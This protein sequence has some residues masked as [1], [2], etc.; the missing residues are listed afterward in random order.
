MQMLRQ[1]LLPGL[2]ERLMM[3]TDCLLPSRLPRRRQTHLRRLCLQDRLPRRLRVHLQVQR[4]RQVVIWMSR[5]LHRN[6]REMK[7]AMTRHPRDARRERHL[8]RRLTP[9]LLT[10]ARVPTRGLALDM[11]V[12][13]LRYLEASVVWPERLPESTS[14]RGPRGRQ[15]HRL[16]FRFLVHRTAT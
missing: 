8:R 2:A 3:I 14:R 11:L 6:E 13:Y 9:K 7:E 5:R 1:W 10:A 4:L 15:Q 16:H 12:R